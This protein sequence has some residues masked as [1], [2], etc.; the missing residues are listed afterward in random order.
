VPLYA[1]LGFWRLNVHGGVAL[2]VPEM[3][4]IPCRGRQIAHNGTY[5]RSGG[6]GLGVSQSELV[7]LVADPFR[8]SGDG[9]ASSVRAFAPPDCLSSFLKEL[10]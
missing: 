8:L 6:V 10:G 7:A 2:A 4:G 5:G 1:R 9:L 3:V